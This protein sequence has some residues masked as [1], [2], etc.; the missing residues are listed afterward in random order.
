MIN[1]LL[2][3]IK[4]GASLWRI[5]ILIYLLQLTMA[6]LLGTQVYGLLDGELGQSLN[7][8]TLREGFDYAVIYDVLNENASAFAAI[9]GQVRGLLLVYLLFSVLLSGG[10]LQEISVGDGSWSSFVKGGLLNFRPFLWIGLL[11]LLVLMIWT[12]LIWGPFFSSVFWALRNLPS[13]KTLFLI[14]AILSVLYILG[15]FFLFSWSVNSRLFFIR[16]RKTVSRAFWRG[17]GMTSRHFFPILGLL[18]MFVLIQAAITTAYWWLDQ[19]GFQKS[20]V[21]LLAIFILQQGFVFFRI[22]WRLAVVS[23]L[24][25]YLTRTLSQ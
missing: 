17:L 24:D 3:G 20:V 21:T 15:L 11:F 12:G 14:L 10:I 7:L 8:E 19:P 4:A 9:F 22:F 2:Q 18:A 6:L 5:A 13:E 25:R 23:G 1:V 16:E